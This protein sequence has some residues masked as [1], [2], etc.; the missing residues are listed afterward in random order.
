MELCVF[1]RNEKNW[2]KKSH[3]DC[4]PRDTRPAPGGI[5][6]LSPG[7]SGPFLYSPGVSFSSAFSLFNLQSSPE[8]PSSATS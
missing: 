2:A 4:S 5:N 1:R 7:E 8:I 3:G 6:V